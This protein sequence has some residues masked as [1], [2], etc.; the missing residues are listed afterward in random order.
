MKKN[1]ILLFL[2]LGITA[3]LVKASPKRTSWGFAITI[4]YIANDSIRGDSLRASWGTE[5]TIDYSAEIDSTD[6]TWHGM[7]VKI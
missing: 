7:Y 5:D 6:S 3:G 4:D 2:L 1:I